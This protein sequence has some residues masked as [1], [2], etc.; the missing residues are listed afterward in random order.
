MLTRKTL[1][2]TFIALSHKE[3]SEKTIAALVQY[4]QNLG[5]TD[6]LQ[7]VLDSLRYRKEQ[8]SRTNSVII[9]SAQELSQDTIARIID[10]VGAPVETPFTVMVDSGVV[11]GFRAE[12]Q[13]NIYDGSLETGVS[14][15]VSSFTQ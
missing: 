10:T 4:V 12:Y 5:Q 7:G 2:E 8:E 14:R 1:T 6:L 15:M 11:G 3:D 13:G 9:S